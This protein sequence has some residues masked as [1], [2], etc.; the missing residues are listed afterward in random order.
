MNG[1]QVDWSTKA[2]KTLQHSL[3]SSLRFGEAQHGSISVEDFSQISHDTEQASNDSDELCYHKLYLNVA[4]YISWP[5]LTQIVVRPNEGVDKVHEIAD[6]DP[7]DQA[8]GR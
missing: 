1:H 2:E 8:R 7:K 6:N 5:P 4:K 3:L